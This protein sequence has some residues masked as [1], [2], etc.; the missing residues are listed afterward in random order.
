M[1]SWEGCVRAGFGLLLCCLGSQ[2][3]A[4]DVDCSRAI[5]PQRC[6]A[7]QQ[8]LRSCLDLA[9]PQRRVCLA[10]YTPPL[11]CQRQRDAKRCEALLAA[12]A[13]CE[14][15]TGAGRRQ[16]IDERLPSGDCSRL[17]QSCAEGACDSSRRRGAGWCLSAPPLAD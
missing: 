11:S 5:A 13:S 2:A 16:C 15:M 6:Q 12:Q 8:G 9:E 7:Y 3:A 1:S 17:P 14:G 10:Y 4:A